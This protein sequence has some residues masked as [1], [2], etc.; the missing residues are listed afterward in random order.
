MQ[1]LREQLKPALQIAALNVPPEPRHFL[2]TS[3]HH[4]HPLPPSNDSL[5]LLNV[6]GH[7]RK[8]MKLPQLLIVG[9]VALAGFFCASAAQAG[10]RHE[11]RHH[12][13][14]YGGRG[15]YAPGVIY[16]NPG[17]GY[18]DGPGY[19]GGP[20]YGGPYYGGPNYGVSFAFGGHRGYRYHHHH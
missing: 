13:H 16:A 9:S 7:N 20:G 8:Y 4:H 19:Y 5:L 15:Y 10:D 17:Y 12:G 2:Q 11:V 3:P 18:Y 14:Y 1:P 6:D